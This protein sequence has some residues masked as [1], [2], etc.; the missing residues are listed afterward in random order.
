MGAADRAGDFGDERGEGNRQRLATRHQHVVMVGARVQRRVAAQR[1][2]QPPVDAMARRG[3]AGFLGDGE[4]DARA[5]PVRFGQTGVGLQREGGGDDALALAGAL[6]LR[7]LLQTAPE[8]LLLV[9]CVWS[10]GKLL[11]AA[12]ATRIQHFASADGRHAGAKSM[13]ALAHEFAWLIG[14]LHGRQLLIRR[15]VQKNRGG[16]P[17]RVLRGL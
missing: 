5:G 3:I 4:T 2:A 16:K 11:A 17:R 9:Q 15:E 6:E 12:G 14:A 13:T 8:G 1:F 10:G 7:A